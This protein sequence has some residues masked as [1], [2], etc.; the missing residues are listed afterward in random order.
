M[1]RP[2]GHIRILIGARVLFDLEAAD[3]IFK[4]KGEKE[5]ADFMRGRGKYEN[6]YVAELGG[7]ALAKGPLWDF[8]VAALALNKPGEE[9][10]VEIGLLCKDTGETALPI[11]RNLDVNGLGGID[12]RIA[13]AGNTLDMSHHKVFGT[14]LLLT[15]NGEDVQLAVDNDIASAIVNFPP[16]G[17]NYNRKPE[18]ALQIFVDGDAVAVGSSSE[19][20]YR[21]Q[22]LE[23]YRDSEASNFDREMEAG[24]FSAFLA[25]VSALNAQFAAPEQPFKISLLTARGADA[26]SHVITAA[27]KLG[28]A[29]N[30]GLYFMG[31]ASKA[32][33]LKAQ[34]P[35]IFF[36]DQA[37]HL[38]ES[39]LYCPTGLVAY[40]ENSPMDLFLKEKEK[41]TKKAVTKT[42]L[43][44]ARNSKAPNANGPKS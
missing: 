10:V 6:D 3:A 33:V 20:I 16:A 32:P 25:K 28:I 7:R 15:R 40:P 23:K 41:I 31:G 11:F 24:P 19:V 44:T 8:A 1:P 43:P 39:K 22:G 36:D 17:T 21:E 13:L 14:D 37:V 26:T 30:G 34:K 2:L 4:E 35:D 18:K 27:E 12:Y 9:P 42:K 5:Y 38:E 29:F